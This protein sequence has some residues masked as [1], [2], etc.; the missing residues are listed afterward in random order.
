M[1][2]DVNMILR[3]DGKRGTDLELGPFNV[4]RVLWYRGYTIKDI[5][6]ITG[7][8]YRKLQSMF[9]MNDI[10]RYKLY[11]T[12]QIMDAIGY[13]SLDEFI[14]DCLNA[15]KF[16]RTKKMDE[17]LE[18][19]IKHQKAFG[20]FLEAD[21][22]A[23]ASEAKWTE[24]LRLAKKNQKNEIISDLL[25]TLEPDDLMTKFNVAALIG[26]DKTVLYENKAAA[27]DSEAD[28]ESSSAATKE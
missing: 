18:K 10:T 25:E 21:I 4:K 15:D 20:T 13:T 11:E 17:L 8:S 19:S 2:R 27:G 14:D 16:K 3:I 26:P 9:E 1:E 7:M 23:I 5:Q 28:S 6:R 12:I 24:K 22:V